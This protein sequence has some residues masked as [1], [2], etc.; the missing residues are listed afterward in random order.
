MLHAFDENVSDCS[1]VWAS[2][3]ST[4]LINSFHIAALSVYPN[5]NVLLTVLL[6][7]SIHYTAEPWLILN[8]RIKQYLRVTL[9]LK[10]TSTI[11]DQD[12]RRRIDSHT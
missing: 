8:K 3:Y 11:A 12:L 4:M 10:K 6:Y 9:V 5:T 2:E 7:S 1:I